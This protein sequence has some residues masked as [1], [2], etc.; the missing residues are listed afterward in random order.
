M[1]TIR[2]RLQHLIAR[3]SRARQRVRDTDE[4]LRLGTRQLEDIGLARFQIEAYLE[5]L[6]PVCCPSA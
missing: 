6:N 5:G 3:L 1:R 4:M 2:E